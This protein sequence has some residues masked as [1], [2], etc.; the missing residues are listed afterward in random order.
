MEYV[1]GG[2]IIG[3][4]A[5]Q[6]APILWRTIRKSKLAD[7]YIQISIGLPEN[8]TTDDVSP[9]ERQGIEQLI[10][11][12]ID[13]HTSRAVRKYGQFIYTK[14]G[15]A[16]KVSLVDKTA[17]RKVKNLQTDQLQTDQFV[18]RFDFSTRPRFST[19]PA[20]IFVSELFNFQLI[21]YSNLARF[22]T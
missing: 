21:F 6:L 22:L 16:V 17:E 5:R 12:Y 10:T 13:E 1:T 2:A 14:H 9:R 7:L 20:K 15:V 19:R 3:A 8:R 4:L 11:N 18:A